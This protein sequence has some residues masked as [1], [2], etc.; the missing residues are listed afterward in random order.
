[1][2]KE[3]ADCETMDEAVAECA[4]N[5]QHWQNFCW[6]GAKDVPNSDKVMLGYITG[7]QSGIT[8]MANYET[9]RRAMEPFLGNMTEGAQAETYGA[10]LHGDRNALAGFMVRVVDEN[11]QP[12]AAFKALFEL[13]RD[14]D[15]EFALDEH[16]LEVVN[17]REVQCYVYRHV[18]YLLHYELKRFDIKV[19]NDF[20]GE[21]IGEMSEDNFDDIDDDDIK[22]SLRKVLRR[23][24]RRKAT[25]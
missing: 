14:N 2:I 24:K 6:F 22:K 20:V 25:T 9:V 8:D 19:D 1:M 10:N 23:H 11:G 15:G 16:D 21:V 5:W 3:I 18:E 4:G 13:T 12:T 17:R 7:P